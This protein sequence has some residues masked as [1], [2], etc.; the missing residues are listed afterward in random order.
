MHAAKNKRRPNFPMLQNRVLTAICIV[1]CLALLL[2]GCGTLPSQ[3]TA[4]PDASPAVSAG[5]AGSAANAAPADTVDA[6]PLLREAIETMNTSELAERF[7]FTGYIRNSLQKHLVTSMF[8]GVMSR[9][10]EA[11]IV[12]GRIAAQP[13]QYYGYGDERYIKKNDR[14]RLLFDD[15]P[16][17]LPFDPFA[18]FSDWLP[19]LEEA[20][21]RPD[22]TILGRPSHV[23]EV[24]ISAK[25]WV[26]RSTSPLFAD[27]D[28]LAE[29][30]SAAG[31]AGG[32]AGTAG[33]A[34]GDAGDTAAEA[35]AGNAADLQAE[36]DRI[37][38]ETVVK[39]TF[40]IT[41]EEKLITQYQTWIV[42]PLPGGGYFDQETFFRFY[43]FGDPSIETTHLPEPEDVLKWVRPYEEL[44]P[45]TQD[46]MI[47]EQ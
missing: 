13:F 14:W 24:R 37:L 18:G 30:G 5:S 32:T 28:Q 17:P 46:E 23:I 19:L 42:M 44:S 8:D 7:W 31:N 27:L 34:A 35:M 29:P 43:R 11:F 6:R 39:T 47:Q 25:D 26:E 2:A 4:F 20:V 45:A 33:N 41:K 21:Q 15:E 22:E 36:M 38:K 10:K 3:K 16:P 40:W 9:P 12:N 1:F